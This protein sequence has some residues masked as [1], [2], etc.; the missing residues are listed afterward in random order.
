MSRYRLD[1]TPEQ[2]AALA[3]HCAH[4]RAVWNAG[5]EQRSYWR[6][7]MTPAP[8]FA[9]QCRQLA[10][11][12]AEH[13][14]LATGSST[15]Q[16][17]ALRDLDRAFRNFFK[18]THRY[19]Q[20]RKRGEGEG[21]RVVHFDASH[22]CR[23][24][25]HVGSVLIPKI[26]AVR[27]RWSRAV[28]EAVSFRVTQD[29]AGRWHVAFAAIPKPIPAPETGEIVGLD[30]GVTISVMTSDGDALHAPG[31]R[32]KKAERLLRLQRR[33]ARAQRGSNRRHRLKHAIAR[34]LAKETD[35]RKDWI[36]QETT[37]LARRYDVLKVEAL[38]VQQMTRRARGKGCHAKAGLNRSILAQGWGQ[39]VAR[40]EQK[41]PGRVRYVDPRY[42]SQRCSECG[43]VAPE[44]RES[45]A[46]FRCV[47]CGFSCN[48]DLNAARNI[49]AGQAVPARRALLRSGGAMKREAPKLE[50]QQCAA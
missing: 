40:L 31:L 2:K 48:A 45:Q 7:R 17:Q 15:V 32:P 6:I 29:R 42:T 3:L 14:W 9:Q 30:R 47:E 24:S 20:W 11:A 1:P 28:P 35:R 46:V 8:G 38:G 4:A 5:L 13:A 23:L 34:L 26:G 44:S 25:R 39:F 18:G 49:A 22:V 41:A 12:R 36:E 10:E 43:H 16:I 50:A 19:P 33:L 21:F 27:F 37:K